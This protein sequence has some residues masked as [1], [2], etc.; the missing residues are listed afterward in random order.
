MPL[1]GC[2]MAYM[3]DE[4]DPSWELRLGPDRAG[5]LLE[6]VVRLLDDGAKM[7]IY[8]MRVRP[9]YRRLLP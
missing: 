6:I 8:A 3:L 7:I 4:G 2:L 1:R 9:R 5:T